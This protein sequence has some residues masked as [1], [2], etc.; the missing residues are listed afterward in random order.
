MIKF[1]NE[2]YWLQLMLLVF[3]QVNDCYIIILVI[4]YSIYV[5][6]SCIV[7]KILRQINSIFT[8]TCGPLLAAI[9]FQNVHW[10]K[11][12]RYIPLPR[13]QQVALLIKSHPNMASA[14]AHKFEWYNI[15]KS[16]FISSRKMYNNILADFESTFSWK[17]SFEQYLLLS[18]SLP[19]PLWCV[20]G[21]I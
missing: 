10:L 1:L 18:E 6:V 17:Y 16:W 15:V 21:S 8:T 20:R 3:L 14:Y 7:Y 19:L 5:Y 12:V 4:D 2:I 11:T 9:V 13:I